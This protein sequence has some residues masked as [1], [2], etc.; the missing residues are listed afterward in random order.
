MAPKKTSNGD[1]ADFQDALEEV[2]Y[3][4]EESGRLADAARAAPDDPRTIAKA[5]RALLYVNEAKTEKRQRKVVEKALEID[6][7]CTDALVLMARSYEEPVDA[8]IL[9]EA[10]VEV[11]ERRLGPEMLEKNMG[12]LGDIPATR[13][14][15]RAMYSLAEADFEAMDYDASFKRYA[16]I[17]ELAE[18]DELGVRFMLLGMLLVA[19][20][21]EE[22]RKIAFEQYAQDDLPFLLWVRTLILYLERDF[23]AAT[24]MLEKA[25]AENPYVQDLLTGQEEWPEDDPVLWQ[26]GS[27]E[28]AAVIVADLATA[29]RLRPLAM[30]WLE[31]GG[32]R[33]GDDRYFGGYTDV[34]LDQI[35]DELETLDDEDLEDELD[36]IFGGG[37]PILLN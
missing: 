29:W 31:A 16:R 13:P 32:G 4:T 17:L 26:I 25:R 27:R 14:Y 8:S 34:D 20:R 15:I 36:D 2:M 22:A 12:E 9:L 28:E 37:G 23:E 6:P 33:P 10:A 11:A 5:E 19:D 35:L 7:G 3:A 21:V 18:N 1:S 24:V 30:I